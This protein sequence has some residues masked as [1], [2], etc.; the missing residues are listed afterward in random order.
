MEPLR[1]PARLEALATIR[2]YV[3]RAAD[4]GGID[5]SAAYRLQLAVDEVAANIVV[6]GCG[7]GGEADETF[8]VHAIIDDD[9]VKIVLEDNGPAF[10]PLEKE[11]PAGLDRPAEDRQVGG[12]GV[13]LAIRSVDSFEYDRV[14]D[15]NRNTLVM[16]RRVTAAG[17]R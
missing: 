8:M 3:R 12:L 13:F 6:H 1:V 5:K 9:A 15:L 7:A 2:E 10:N 4:A 17:A 14:G 11:E 16:R